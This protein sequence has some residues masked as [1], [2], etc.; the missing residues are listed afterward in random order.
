L[1]SPGISELMWKLHAPQSSRAATKTPHAIAGARPGYR[2]AM[3]QHAVF[4]PE[5]R[6]ACYRMAVL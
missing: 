1:R 5:E 2:T 3:G 4:S 6:T